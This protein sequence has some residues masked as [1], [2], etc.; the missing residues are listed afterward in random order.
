GLRE[1]VS[2][3]A[4]LLKDIAV[5]ILVGV[6]N[7]QQHAPEAG[8][9]VMIARRKVGAAVKRLAVWGKEGSQRP[10]A[11]PAHRLHRDLVAAVNVW[12]LVPV[13]LDSH[14]TLVDDLGD[15]GIIIGFPVHHMA[16][17]APHG[18]NIEQNGLILA[19]GEGEGLLAPFIP[20]D[21]LLHRGAEV[22]RSRAREGIQSVG[23]HHSSLNAEAGTS[24][25]PRAISKTINFMNGWSDGRCRPSWLK[26]RKAAP[27]RIRNPASHQPTAHRWRARG[28]PS[29]ADIRQAGPGGAPDD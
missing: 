20:L 21:G 26:C 15:L 4:R 9:S 25:K 7:R 12:A 29:S 3:Q 22:G 11:L 13:H 1:S 5:F 16:P 23:G 27:A 8:A 17:M 2:H 24:A 6:G 18:P 19:L 14:K 28:F 10:S